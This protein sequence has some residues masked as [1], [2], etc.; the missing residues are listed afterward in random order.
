[1]FLFVFLAMPEYADPGEP[2]IDIPAA[3]SSGHT[4]GAADREVDFPSTLI[5]FLGNLRSGLPGSHHEH[6]TRWKG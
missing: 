6:C 2:I 1:V 4:S 5:K 3:I